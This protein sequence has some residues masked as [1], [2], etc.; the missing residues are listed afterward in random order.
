M[1]E[2]PDRSL[3]RTF[4][5]DDTLRAAELRFKFQ[6]FEY[7]FVWNCLQDAG[8]T[9]RTSKV[10]VTGYQYHAPGENGPAFDSWELVVA[11]LDQ[12]S[13]PDVYGTLEH[14]IS[15]EDFR[16]V[17][18]IQQGMKLRQQAL[19]EV[20][21]N[22]KEEWARH[23]CTDDIDV[24]E[25]HI[26]VTTTETAELQSLRSSNTHGSTTQTDVGTNLYMNGKKS[27]K[28][29][30]KEAAASTANQQDVKLE[31]PS[32]LQVSRFLQT[33]EHVHDTAA[34]RI[35][36]HKH[37]YPYWRFLLST[38]HSI[39]FF[40]A[41]SKYNLLTDF[42]D[43][44][45]C[46]EGYALQIDGFDKYASMEKILDLLVNQFLGGKEPMP[47]GRIERHD[48]AY[49]VL[50]ESNPWRAPDLVE[51][52]ILIGRACA[53][54]ASES[55][56]PIFLI[57]HSLDGETLRS[58]LALDALA[59]LVVNSNVEN[60]VRAICLVVSVDHVAGS[61]IMFTPQV[62]A[63]LAWIYVPVH[64]HEPHVKELIML[65]VPNKKGNKNK[66]ETLQVEHIKHVEEVLELLAPRHAEVMQVLAQLQLEQKL[67]E[68]WVQMPV[69]RKQCKESHIIAKD[70]GLDAFL[71]ELTDH[72]LVQIDRQSKT[73][74]FIRAPFDRFKLQQIL[75]FR[76]GQAGP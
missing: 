58:K 19:Q 61:E 2:Q 68:S 29:K 27:S 69:F 66:A 28:S 73:G 4:E 51:R 35:D 56:V 23:C 52:A 76:P 62:A 59:A 65:S 12:F 38:N 34:Q 15:N 43:N 17:E 22:S 55:L 20:F 14:I 49:H 48:G 11:F 42:C 67:E 63:N 57:V 70:S 7:A 10:S 46:K 24:S 47:R 32:I 26:D 41:G 30:G 75:K 39:V 45:L 53:Y 36:I 37:N 21:A 16:S 44:E 13:L 1:H 64:T 18:E 8:W 9:Y 5:S 40:G 6:E 54:E 74:E 60:N 25:L 50:G 71:N 3:K 72:G 33:Q 31:L